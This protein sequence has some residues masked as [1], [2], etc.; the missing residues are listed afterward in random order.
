MT[1][2][3]PIDGDGD[4]QAYSV[5]ASVR[6]H[7]D[8]IRPYRGLFN[9]RSLSSLDNETGADID[10]VSLRARAPPVGPYSSYRDIPQTVQWPEY[11][12][13]HPRFTFLIPADLFRYRFSS[14]SFR[15]SL[16]EYL[17]ARPTYPDV[18]HAG[19]IHFDGYGLLPYSR[20]HDIPMFVMGRGAT[21]NNYPD[22]PDPGPQIVE[23][24]LEHCA[25]IICVSNAL[26]DIASDIIGSDERVHTVAN[27]ASPEQFP[28]ERRDAIRAELNVAESDKIVLFVGSFTERKG[29]R[30]MSTVLQSMDRPDTHFLFV[31]HHGDLK[32][33][34][35]SALR[36]ATVG[37]ASRVYDGMPPFALRRLFVAADLVQ[38]PSYAEGRP[39]VIYEAMAS[40]TAVLSTDIGGVSEQVVDGETGLLV[41]CGDANALDRGLRELLSAPATLTE[42]G[43]NGYSRLLEKGWT[44]RNHA[45]RVSAIHRQAIEQTATTR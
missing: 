43:E 42:M 32:D 4:E 9:R 10:A 16:R 29:I 34:L 8:P 6:S 19:H 40:R 36:S 22:L 17:E 35:Q 45:R 2:T 39:N 23:E 13:D 21:L 3:A 31:G 1:T 38:L 37:A 12:L 44:W 18:L 41:P 24:T 15:E 28:N 20:E 33:H 26:A 25:G 5:L 27:G 7:P 11:D 14:H 30:E